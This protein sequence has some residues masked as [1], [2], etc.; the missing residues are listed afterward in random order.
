MSRAD[1]LRRLRNDRGLKQ[2]EAA[3]RAGITTSTLST[4]EQPHNDDR[5]MQRG[6]A[7]ALLRVLYEAEPL[8]ADDIERYRDSFG[9]AA[10]DVDQAIGD[11]QRAATATEGSE[12]AE[13]IRTNIGRIAAHIG[14]EPTSEL[15][16][17]LAA[18][19]SLASAQTD[20]DAQVNIASQ[21]TQFSV[22]NR[23][24]DT[25]SSRG[26]VISVRQPPEPGPVPGA[27]SE[28]YEHYT[29]DEATNELRRLVA[30][31]DKGTAIDARDFADAL[32]NIAKKTER[33]PASS[34]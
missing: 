28:R 18:V 17:N 20:H 27:V 4:F 6:N 10:R 21:L 16:A 26:R 34:E 3:E 12:W 9:L 19:V 1:L 25:E 13:A 15:I 30:L 29:I 5:A 8:D 11:L 24:A 14:A 2:Q 7:I 31:R 33:K 22:R 23:L 32:T